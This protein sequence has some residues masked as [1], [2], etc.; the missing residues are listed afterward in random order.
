M[1]GQHAAPGELAQW[2]AVL[3]IIAGWAVG[4]GL[5]ICSVAIAVFLVAPMAVGRRLSGPRPAH[6]GTRR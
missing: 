6:T 1:K 5:R 3:L 4:A 2:R